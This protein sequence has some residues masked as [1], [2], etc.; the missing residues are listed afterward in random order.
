M[1]ITFPIMAIAD[2]IA[3]LWYNFLSILPFWQS[4]QIEKGGSQLIYE[5]T[6]MPFILLTARLLLFQEILN[7][8]EG[9]TVYLGQKIAVLFYDAGWLSAEQHSSYFHRGRSGTQCSRTRG[10]S[11]R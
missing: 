1:L 11:T 3:S 7:H 5:S 8:Q 2:V 9:F 6:C 10:E 4:Y